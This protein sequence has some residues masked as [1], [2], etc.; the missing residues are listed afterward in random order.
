MTNEY[1]FRAEKLNKFFGPTH[2]NNDVSISI[3]K[4]EIRGLI[5][6]NGSGKSTLISLISGIIQKDSG[7]MFL[8][9][10]PYEPKTPLDAFNHKIGTVV[11]ELG[12]VDGL[13]I[14]VNIFLGRLD[15]FN[16]NGVIDLQG[17]YKAASEHLSYWNLGKFPVQNLASTLSVEEKKMVELARALSVNPNFLIL[18]EITTAISLNN[19]KLLYSIIEQF[20]KQG[21]SVL[22]ITHD[23]EEIIKITDN[24]TIMRDGVVVDTRKS[25]ELTPDILKRLMVGRELSG[26]YYRNDWE[27][28]YE[29]DVV[30]SVCDLTVEE[31]F[32]DV[33]FDL[34]KGEILGICGLSDAG[35][36]ELGETIFGVIKPQKG[37]IYFIS[38]NEKIK[39]KNS[40]HARKLG[41]GYVPKDRDKQALMINDSVENNICLPSIEILQGPFGYIRPA[42]IRK[43]SSKI[44]NDFEIKAKSISQYIRGLS[45]GNKQKIN[46]ARW[47]NE[48]V[49]ILIMDCPT[50]GVDVGVKAYIYS[51]MNEAKKQGLSIVMIS[52][53][54]P[55]LIG[56]CDRLLVMR[57]GKVVKTFYRSSGF[58]EESIMEVMM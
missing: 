18:D 48:K 44:V 47:M 49:R 35:I 17:L 13:P 4:G 52:D 53:E 8:D 11:Q 30:L 58:T 5:G 7:M 15:M 33:S 43:L 51:V 22:L 39:V 29:D 21:K 20:K 26:S 23:L 50:R 14:G 54:L 41:I 45:G 56:M 2:A 57:E 6:E 10:E 12:L 9:G 31:H 27:D 42:K 38:L 55:E 3:Q 25:C 19:R 16:K 46:F 1:I 37:S 40:I 24:I 34:H 28:Q 36:H 32:E